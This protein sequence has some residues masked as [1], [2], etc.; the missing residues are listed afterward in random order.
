MIGDYYNA[1]KCYDEAI[2]IGGSTFTLH[3][4]R[5]ASHYHLGNYQ[6]A[7]Q[8]AS[9]TIKLAGNWFKGYI[10]KGAALS[11]LGLYKEAQ[12]TYRKGL[13]VDPENRELSI[14]L[15]KI[16]A[17]ISKQEM[18]NHPKVSQAERKI[19][20][21]SIFQRCRELPGPPETHD[22]EFYR[23]HYRLTEAEMKDHLGILGQVTF[24]EHRALLV[25][26]LEDG[27]E[28]FIGHY[29]SF[30]GVVSSSLSLNSI[31]VMIATMFLHI[32]VTPS[33]RLSIIRR[34]MSKQ[35]RS[36]LSC[37]NNLN[38]DIKVF[39][40]RIGH[41]AIHQRKGL[42]SRMPLCAVAILKDDLEVFKLLHDPTVD[43]V[44][45]PLSLSLIDY[46]CAHGATRIAQYLTPTYWTPHCSP[47]WWGSMSVQFDLLHKV[48]LS[49]HDLPKDIAISSPK[50]SMPISEVLA[51]MDCQDFMDDCFKAGYS[52]SDMVTPR[53]HSKHPTDGVE[54]SLL[55]IA[56]GQLNHKLI[57]VL[58]R[59][60]PIVAHICQSALVRSLLS[61]PQVFINYARYASPGPFF[62]G[63]SIPYA[64]FA[65]M[66]ICSS[67][68]SINHVDSKQYQLASHHGGIGRTK[69]DMMLEFW[70]IISIITIYFMFNHRNAVYLLE[71]HYLLLDP[72]VLSI[73]NGQSDADKTLYFD[74]INRFKAKKEILAKE[75]LAK[76][77][78]AKEKLA[79]EALAKE[80]LAKEALA[81]ETLAK[82]ASR[83]ELMDCKINTD[84]QC[85]G[86]TQVD[87]K[88]AMLRQQAK[89]FTQKLDLA[90]K[91][92]AK[93][94]RVDQG[95]PQAGRVL[96]EEAMPVA[97]KEA[98][99]PRGVFAND[100]ED[101][102]IDMDIDV[103][104]DAVEVPGPVDCTE[105]F[106]RAGASPAISNFRRLLTLLRI[107]EEIES[108]PERAAAAKL[109]KELRAKQIRSKFV[110]WVAQKK[111]AFEARRLAL[112]QDLAATFVEDADVT[113]GNHLERHCCL[114][115]RCH[116]ATYG[117][118]PWPD[119]SASSTLV[120]HGLP[121]CP[122]VL[123][124]LSG[125][126]ATWLA[127]QTQVV[128]HPS[129]NDNPHHYHITHVCRIWP[130]PIDHTLHPEAEYSDQKVTLDWL[131]ARYS[132]LAIYRYVCTFRSIL[133][134]L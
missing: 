45:N 75:A 121:Q 119:R 114:L 33:K 93:S 104:E 61:R 7:L 37:P 18:K 42:A 35:P 56:V 8:D 78:L 39:D 84:K 82:E 34:V 2:A 97:N 36:V 55:G 126:K 67:S 77:K 107:Q 25:W 98:E 71:N 26:S 100:S 51:R 9:D 60:Y 4:N 38:L 19:L 48:I 63:T 74:A 91:A 102:I 90:R 10:R 131:L 133:E 95:R 132:S 81:K 108:L 58:A 118:A 17:E 11:A 41:D 128:G 43:R 31:F 3:S 22:A 70:P 57:K 54:C 101:G 23:V 13:L 92:K 99:N 30:V 28:S 106:R 117:C 94:P 6:L 50:G 115:S 111:A 40:P 109:A 80:A 1:V 129:N 14:S 110:Q 88:K 134:E 124:A 79:K 130:A 65:G 62:P 72:I 103:E 47:I 120:R 83:R 59:H 68:F 127:P 113:V 44:E 53:P 20:L 105:L 32:R 24:T 12:D 96:P 87:E 46:A 85:Y 112:V 69:L 73:I 64:S 116:P 16:N 89:A 29:T 86:K 49:N 125:P 5:S 66:L 15:D 123:I 76:E 52:L 27:K 21:S 122:G